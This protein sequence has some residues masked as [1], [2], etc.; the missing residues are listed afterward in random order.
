[1][2]NCAYRNCSETVQRTGSAYCSDGC[3]RYD[4]RE[5][6]RAKSPTTSIVYGPVKKFFKARVGEKYCKRKVFEEL[7]SM[8]LVDRFDRYRVSDAITRFYKLGLL[9]REQETTGYAHKYWY[10]GAE[11][12]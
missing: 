12:I 11:W 2:R 8:G 3:A 7:Y 9:S 5:T 6:F 1:M 4:A 10:E